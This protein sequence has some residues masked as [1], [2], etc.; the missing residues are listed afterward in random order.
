MKCRRR[1]FEI[2]YR[3]EHKKIKKLNF[4]KPNF[5][6]HYCLPLTS[7]DSI[8]K[9]LFYNTKRVVLGDGV[10]LKSLHCFSFWF[11]M[12]PYFGIFTNLLRLKGK[13]FE[14]VR[15]TLVELAFLYFQCIFNVWL[16]FQGFSCFI[17]QF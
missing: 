3:L 1:F 16:T 9:L 17:F 5:M 8:V 11:N 15:E 12:L 10:S 14:A 4:F 7:C 6:I 2:S 13:Y